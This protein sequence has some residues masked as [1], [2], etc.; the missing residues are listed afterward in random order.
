MF[1]YVFFVLTGYKFRA[2]STNPY[3]TSTNDETTPADDDDETDVVW[4]SILFRISFNY[5][6]NLITARKI[7]IFIH[8]FRSF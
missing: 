8:Y 5:E 7:F 2:A 4:V 6:K 1:T 3:F